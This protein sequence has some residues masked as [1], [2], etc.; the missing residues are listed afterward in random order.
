M[1][2]EFRKIEK[3]GSQV[4]WQLIFGRSNID[5]QNTPKVAVLVQSFDQRA[6][7]TLLNGFLK[8]K[9]DAGNHIV[10]NAAI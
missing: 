10:F 1:I 8:S 3:P 9:R 4:L 7:L 5:C 2:R 6:E